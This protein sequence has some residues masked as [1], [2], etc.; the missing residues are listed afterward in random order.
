MLVRCFFNAQ[1]LTDLYT[2]Y[3]KLKYKHTD[4]G[5]GCP[6]EVIKRYLDQQNPK[7]FIIESEFKLF[8]N[9]LTDDST[10]AQQ[11]QNYLLEP[12]SDTKY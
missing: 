6:T 2:K 12:Y 10:N 4:T 7:K 8:N 5:I 1:S 3:S 9:D 11:D